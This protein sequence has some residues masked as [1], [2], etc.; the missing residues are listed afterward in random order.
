[1]T[2]HV[3]VLED[4]VR[5]HSE[6]RS[7][8]QRQGFEAHIFEHRIAFYDALKSVVPYAAI[9]DNFAP[10]YQDT[11][12]EA[13]IG[14]QVARQL[15]RRHPIVKIAIHSSELTETVMKLE[16]VVFFSTKPV[17]VEELERFLKAESL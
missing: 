15:Q 11:P 4:S 10:P 13:D 9:L 5:Y 14:Y 8:I 1:M 6:L 7:A 3:F 16:H 17:G 2:R 12:V